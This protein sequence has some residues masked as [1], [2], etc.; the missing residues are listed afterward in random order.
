MKSKSDENGVGQIL[1]KPVKASVGRD[2]MKRTQT[3]TVKSPNG[4]PSKTLNKSLSNI[5]LLFIHL[6]S[7]HA[8]ESPVLSFAG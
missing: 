5:L 7:F 8:V 4:S 6:F 3:G 1:S 2:R